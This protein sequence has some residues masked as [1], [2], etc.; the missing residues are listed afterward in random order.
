[1]IKKEGCMEI[2][3]L[4]RQGAG[5]REIA[6]H[7]GLSRNTVRKYLRSDGEPRYAARPPRCGK[8]AP[9]EGYIRERLEAARPH[10]IPAT[11]IEREIRA[12]GYQGSIRLLR[13]F[14]AELRP[15]PRP[16]PVVRFETE[17]GQQMQ[18]DWGVFRRGRHPLSAF[19]ATLGWSR[20]SYVEFVT[21]ERFET[22]KHCHESAFAYF[23]GIPREVLYD[24][25]RTVVQQRHAYG[26]DQHRFHPAL[27]DFARHTGFTPRLCRPYRAKTKGK[28]ERFIGY[29]RHS[30][31]VPLCTR[32]SQG[33]LV[34]D[35]ETANLEVRTWL[36]DVANARTHATT[37]AVP[38]QRWAEERE[39][40]L[41]LALPENVTPLARPR[42]PTP[43]RFAPEMLQH[44]LAVYDALLQEG[45]S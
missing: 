43:Q 6:R 2:K 21:N 19:V 14:M 3:I 26:R 30:F 31:F 22:L 37:E 41:P 33:G 42:A 16:D 28:V 23:Q 45:Q 15:T 11:V 24:N 25:M 40:L 32:L 29:L 35:V 39:A 10:W 44:P 18:V 1:M 36:R 38:A 4:H 27:W 7:T 34:L 13:Y 5:I 12:L 17:P 8:L 20:Y 9:Y